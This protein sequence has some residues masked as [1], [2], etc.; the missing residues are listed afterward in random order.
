[1]KTIVIVVAYL[2]VAC[3]FRSDFRSIR[4]SRTRYQSMQN[5]NFD[6]QDVEEMPISNIAKKYPIG[7]QPEF[8]L[9]DDSTIETPSQQAVV[10]VHFALF[11][12]N[13]ISALCS[14]SFSS[15]IDMANV[16]TVFLISVLLGDIGELY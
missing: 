9:P 16:F 8:A 6:V 14:Y 12:W 7:S 1:M 5:L 10:A 15:P 4:I 2:A 13:V 11:F 3:A